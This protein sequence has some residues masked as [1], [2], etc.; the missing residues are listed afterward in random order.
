MCCG[1]REGIVWRTVAIHHQTYLVVARQTSRADMSQS[2]ETQS[3]DG[4]EN[5]DFCAKSSC[6]TEAASSDEKMQ[7]EIQLST[8]LESSL[9]RRGRRRFRELQANSAAKIRLDRERAVLKVHGREPEVL[10]VRKKL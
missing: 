1:L 3:N 6:Q 8:S 5:F 9:C 4:S 2:F 7:V 10:A